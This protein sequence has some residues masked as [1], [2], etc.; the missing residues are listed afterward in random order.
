M[1]TPVITNAFNL[2]E[3]GITC[4]FLSICL[5]SG[6]KKIALEQD[7]RKLKGDRYNEN[8]GK[9]GSDLQTLTSILSHQYHLYA[10]NT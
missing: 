8:I 1:T 6:F 4:I 3:Q 10:K 5:V 9:R 7:K 2:K